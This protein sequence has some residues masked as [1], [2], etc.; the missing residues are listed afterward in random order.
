MKGHKRVNHPVNVLDLESIRAMQLKGFRV[1][2]ICKILRICE[3][4][5]SS[6]CHILEAVHNN[7]PIKIKRNRYSIKLVK[8]YCDKHKLTFIEP[9]PEPVQIEIQEPEEA[10]LLDM[11]PASSS[12]EESNQ[13][14]IDQC[15]E[16]II[17]L[18]EQRLDLHLQIHRNNLELNVLETA[19]INYHRKIANL[20]KGADHNDQKAADG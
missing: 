3:T 13:S 7:K 6:Y 5:T 11:R 14:T 1:F 2:E 9:L 18:E 17:K 8:A 12:S 10:P 20:L 19:I 16:E 15:I 4:T